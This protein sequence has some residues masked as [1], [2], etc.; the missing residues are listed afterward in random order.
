MVRRIRSFL[1]D[2][3]GAATVE[4]VVLFLPLVALVFTSFQISLAYHFAL[5]SQ[6]AVENGARFAAVRDAA[7]VRGD[8]LGQMP[9]IKELS[10]TA[11]STAEVGDACSVAGTCAFANTSNNGPWSCA[12]A[13]LASPTCNAAAFDA[14]YQEIASLA[15]L[16]QPEDVVITYR[17]AGLGFAGG[18]FVP[19]I[20]VSILE[21]PFF[22]QFLFEATAFGGNAD[23][24]RPGV[25]TLPAVTATAVAEDLS[26]SSG[27]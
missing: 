8:A 7:V 19:V 18:P 4:Y 27:L 5:T 20:E 22:L 13:D 2:R 25:E 21:K 10:R 11:P 14:I 12:G 24:A 15:Y 3:R 6:K 16:L 1:S 9:M 23:Q 26:T 17:D